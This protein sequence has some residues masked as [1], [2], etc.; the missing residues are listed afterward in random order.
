MIKKT[1]GFLLFAIVILL[2]SSCTP[3]KRMIY[4]NDLENVKQANL[5][6]SLQDNA[7]HKIENNEVLSIRITSPTLDENA[8]KLFN[9]TN[10]Y[11][12]GTAIAS[13]GYLVGN[14]GNIEIPLLGPIKAAG[15]T[16]SQLKQTVLKQLEEKRLLLDPIVEIRFLN[17]EVTILGEVVKPMVINVP[18]EKI[19][20]IKA[21]GTAGDITPFGRKDNVMILRES[22]GKKI[23]TRVNLNSSTFLQSPFYY[24]QPNDVVYVETTSNRASSV[25]KTRVIL[26]VILSSITLAMYIVDRVTR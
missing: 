12:S 25:D 22:E 23:V 3:V 1:H 2:G 15:L 13:T 24:L 4:F 14:D 10:D 7:E 21:L 9:T 8:Y 20:L 18:T 16:K 19:S 6:S 17:Y 11:K 26:P 5:I